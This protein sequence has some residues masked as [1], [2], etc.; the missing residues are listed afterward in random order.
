MKNKIVF[1]V[2]LIFFIILGT[3]LGT[4]CD[5]TPY[6]EWLGKDFTFSTGV[7]DLN[8]HIMQITLGLSVS[9]NLAQGLMMLLALY[10]APKLAAKIQLG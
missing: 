8:L 7:Y 9:I 5:N 6:L 3:F 4:I 10:V 2:T 1:V